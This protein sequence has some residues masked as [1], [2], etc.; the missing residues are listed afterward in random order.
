MPLRDLPFDATTIVDPATRRNVVRICPAGQQGTHAYFTATSFDADGRLIVSVEID[1][2]PQLCRYDLRRRACQQITQLET[3]GMQAYCVI[4][5]RNAAVVPEGVSLTLVDLDTGKTKPLYTPPAGYSCSLP[6]A[7]ASGRYLAFAVTEQLPQFCTANQ[8]YSRMEE[9][10]YA[11]VRC[12]ICRADLDTGDVKIIWGEMG[13]LSHVL[14]H[15]HDPDTIVFCHEGGYLANHRL[16]VV[17]ARDVHKKRP[18]CLFE[19][20]RNH[21]LVHE[22]FCGDGILGVQCSVWPDDHVEMAWGDPRSRHSILFLDMSG[23]IIA[24]YAHPADRSMHVQANADRSVIVADTFSAQWTS[25]ADETSLA[26]LT[27]GPNNVLS[28]TQLCRHGTSW[29]SQHSHPH[30]SFSPDGKQVV[31]TSDAGGSLSPYVVTI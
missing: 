7:D 18:R 25:P 21:F 3:M 22:F 2:K 15:P 31:F 1:G 13:W 8:I 12:L 26:I 6:T 9:H 30:P 10:F 24:E 11:R 5:A 29:K 4:P 23:R 17:S 19:E 14:I 16:W 27:P 28:A 20:S